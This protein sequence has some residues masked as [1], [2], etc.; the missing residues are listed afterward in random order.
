[1][2]PKEK[3]QWTVFP[4]GLT[5]AAFPLT[6]VMTE[7]LREFHNS[8]RSFYD[9][10]ILYGK[11]SEHLDLIDRILQRFAEFGIHVNLSKCQFMSDEVSFTGH[12]INRSGVKPETS[13]VTDMVNSQRP[14][15]ARELKSLLGMASYFRKFIPNFSLFHR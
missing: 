2:L 5:D 8:A 1:M 12:L 9:D 4:F 13:K 14:N 11:R 7:I 10:C 3:Y 15:T 6:Y